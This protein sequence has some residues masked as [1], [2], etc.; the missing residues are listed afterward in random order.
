MLGLLYDQTSTP[1]ERA[2]ALCALR[3]IDKWVFDRLRGTER[4]AAHIRSQQERWVQYLNS[5]VAMKSLDEQRKFE[6]DNEPPF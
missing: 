2:K 3:R 4:H 1:K 6:Q 5:E